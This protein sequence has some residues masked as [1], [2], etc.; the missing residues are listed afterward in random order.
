MPENKFFL[1]EVSKTKGRTYLSDLKYLNNVE[2]RRLAAVFEKIP[3][4]DAILFQRNDVSEYL[5]G[6][7]PKQV[8][9]VSAKSMLIFTLRCDKEAII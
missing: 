1:E 7:R 9:A 6:D 3:R 5:A 2:K 4:K 8:Y